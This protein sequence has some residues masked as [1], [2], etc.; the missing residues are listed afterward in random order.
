MT[1]LVP[2]GGA[3]DYREEL[4]KALGTISVLRNALE[5]RQRA[6][7]EPVAIVGAGCRFPGRVSD[8]ESMWRLLTDGV[9]AIGPFPAERGDAAPYY[10]PDPEAPAKAY[11]LDAGY[12]PDVTGF[13]AQ[14]FGISPP[15][16]AGM[17]P[18]QRLAL[19]VT[20]EA[21]ERAGIPPGSLGG[22]RTGVYM[23][24][25]TNDYVRLRQEFGTPESIDPY[26]L[27]GESSFIAGRVAHTFDL[28]GPVQVVDTACSSSL[29]AVHQ[30]ATALRSGDIDLALAGGVNVILSPYGFVLVSKARAVSPDGRCKT[31][32]ASADGY[33]RGEGCGVVVLKR[34]S[35]AERDG[36]D[37]LA[38]I[39]GTAVNHDG[40]ASGISVPNGPAQ[41]DVI[42]DALRD[43]GVEPGRI[44]YVEAHG[45]GTPLGD[46]VEL[47]ALDTVLAD[48]GSAAGGAPVYVGSVK[49]NIGHLEAAAGI[50]GLIKVLLAVRHGRVPPSLHF[51]RP[52][53][54]VDWRAMRLEVATG[55]TDWPSREGPRVAGLSSFGASGTNAH[56]VIEQAPARTGGEAQR[57]EPAPEPAPAADVRPAHLLPLSAHSE[58]ALRDLADR[59]AAYLKDRPDVP[60]QTLTRAA[61]RHR[62]H[63]RVRTSLVA[64]D[65]AGLA[66]GLAELAQGVGA[67]RARRALPK[68]RAKVAFLFPGQ[69]AQYA[70]M[71]LE[72]HRGEPAFREALENCAELLGTRPAELLSAPRSA[73]DTAWAQPA[74]FAV[75]YALAEL[76]RS[77]G[78]EP[79]AV[80]GHS[81]GEYVAACVSG[82]LSLEDAVRLVEL[83]GRLMASVTAPGAMV[84]VPLGEE[85]A[86]EAVHAAEGRA[87][88]VSIAA[89]NGPGSTVLSGAA[90]AVDEIVAELTERGVAP[91]RLKVSHA[92]HSPLLD[93]VLGELDRAAAATP[94]AAPAV[95]LVSNLTGEPATPE[96]LA[97][98][99]YWSRHAREP[100]R[101]AP[102]MR[103]LYDSGV[104]A[105]VEAGPGRT[106]LGLGA[107][108]LGDADLMWVPSIRRGRPEAAGMLT[109][110][111]LLYEHGAAVDWSALHGTGPASCADLPT[112]PFQHEAYDAVADR[113]GGPRPGRAAAPAGDSVRY[114]IRWEA[115]RPAT[116]PAP[117]GPA[118]GRTLLL[119]DGSGLADRLAG[120]LTRLGGE[121]HLA[122]PADAP[123]TA[124]AGATG[125]VHRVPP[126]DGEALRALLRSLGPLDRVVH[127]W[128]LDVPPAGQATPLDLDN[129]Q[130]LGAESVLH[131]VQELTD[132]TAGTPRLWLVTRGAR[133]T[134][135][136]DRP[137]GLAAAPLDGLGKVIALEHSE[138]WGGG[139]DLDPAAGDAEREADRLT[140]EILGPGHDDAVALRGGARLVPR[141]VPAAASAAPAPPVVREDAAY[142]ITGGLG[143][144]GLTLAD[145]LTGLGARHLVLTGR[146]GLPDRAAWEDPGLPAAVRE[147]VER[148]RAL[149]RR[150]A[151]V[152]AVAADV[153]DAAAMADVLRGVEETGRTLRGVI[154]A[155]GTA[156]AAL[157]RDLTPAGL[158]EVMRSKVTGAWTLHRLLGDAPLD[159]FVGMSSIASVWGSADLGAYAAANQFL[160]ALAAYRRSRGLAG[161]SVNWG[162]WHVASGLGGDELLRRL[163]ANGLRT[164]APDAALGHLAD[165]LAQGA[166]QAVVCDAVWPTLKP[167]LE[168]RRPRPLLDRISDDLAGAGDGDGG[169][170]LAGLLAAGPDER[171]RS[172][173]DYL[174]ERL[175]EQLGLPAEEFTEDASL[176]ELGLDS[177]GVV[178][179][180]NRFRGDLGV[181]LDARAFF[182]EPA[183][184]WPRL[185]A[186]EIARQHEGDPTT[187]APGETRHDA[188]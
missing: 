48:G 188:A 145:W 87:G 111:G 141:L 171:E 44:G 39:R 58:A 127:L 71:G 116:A 151:T 126:G 60:P 115:T 97:A 67:P 114:E 107:A 46:P 125:T 170:Y 104:T 109:G 180:L 16:A 172:L 128:A 137:E 158:H 94:H 140:A 178:Q 72:L 23:G 98:P 176:V 43:A 77:W 31:F 182:E 96:T 74:L 179:L 82:V 18:Q 49:T 185:L 169:R 156:G 80:M 63:H 144:L 4:A 120:R 76:W 35:D 32:D 150:G 132:G 99:G 119:A 51:T 112:Y 45:T 165:L 166:T 29:V 54:N 28:R 159:F 122:V 147:R 161:L 33:A 139:V 7:R 38:V 56:L 162:P 37:I 20:W 133:G 25:S 5:E 174:R 154:H 124:G 40:R 19:E 14:L 86:A 134:A 42:R 24:A 143:G 34:L 26:Q 136:A 53:P 129:A 130:R 113:G 160:D 27:L 173:G 50:A 110:L 62:D 167:L 121:C 123:D 6:A 13:D 15:E 102:G 95:P 81:V 149:E 85:A 11:V 135:A 153:C 142:L 152:T 17:D 3:P 65:T 75:E 10:D 186:T 92:F 88:R 66:R 2:A 73:E 78:V 84:A 93:G 108:A 47:R 41:Q 52:N 9:D 89:V 164:L 57:D 8:P 117:G 61:A 12:L 187:D 106:L 70:G 105:F 181:R 146:A 100:V 138:L 101:F 148:V 157:L 83:R 21:L 103:A 163:E 64:G 55:L 177:L 30:A 184:R 22:S 36:D 131:L 68:H 175:A 91:K 90:D 183:P 118:P 155:A 79:A 69:G 168:S 59:W 1:S